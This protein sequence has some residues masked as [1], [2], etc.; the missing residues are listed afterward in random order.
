MGR[1][2]GG[3]GRRGGGGGLFG[4]GAKKGGGGGGF[5]GR[6]QAAPT[7]TQTR[8][9]STLPARR[10]NAQTKPAPAQQQT[11]SGGMMGGIGGMVAQG[12]AFGAGSAIA[13]RAIGAAADGLSGSGAEG[14]TEGQEQRQQQDLGP[15]GE[16]KNL[17]YQCLEQ[18]QGSASAC[19]YYFDALRTCQE[20]QKF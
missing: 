15:C 9:A 16:P 14:V 7:K 6:K 4:G 2:G 5:F 8:S 10:P 13:H 19:Q 12:M 11:Q 17:L 18:Q 1:R 3:G 20:N